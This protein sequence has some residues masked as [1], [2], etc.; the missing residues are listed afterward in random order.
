MGLSALLPCKPDRAQREVPLGGLPTPLTMIGCEA[1]GLMFAVSM[2]RLPPT[3][4]M[5]AV[6]KVWQQGV[7]AHMGAND[8]LVDAR[9]LGS[10]GLRAVVRG[11]TADGRV[12]VAHVAWLAQGDIAVH[13]IV[14]GSKLNPDAA[15]TLFDS[16]K[17]QMP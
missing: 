2:A 14:F 6:L 12:V 13:A 10:T 1:D 4:D 17:V 15:D 5:P 16:L 11:P 9:P 8:G 3:T 7:V